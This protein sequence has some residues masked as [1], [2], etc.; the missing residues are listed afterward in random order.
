MYTLDNFQIFMKIYTICILSVGF[1]Y[2]TLPPFISI[3]RLLIDQKNSRRGGGF[4]RLLASREY[5][6]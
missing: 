6:F 4:I 1:Y 3:S 2:I 5:N